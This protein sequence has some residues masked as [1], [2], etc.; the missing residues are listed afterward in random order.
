MLN[1]SDWERGGDELQRSCTG[2]FIFHAKAKLEEKI[3]IFR[4]HGHTAAANDIMV[5]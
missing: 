5:I 2:I 3:V 1:A 4:E